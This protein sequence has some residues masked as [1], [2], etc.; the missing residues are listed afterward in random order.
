MRFGYASFIEERFPGLS[1][2]VMELEGVWADVDATGPV[3]RFTARALKRLQTET[4]GGFAEIQA[5]RRA[6]TKM[7]LK[8]TRYRCAS[9]ALLRRLRKSGSLPALHPLIDLCNAA[10]VAS[11]VPVA[12]FDMDRIQGDLC[13]RRAGGDER[14]LAFSGAAE[15]PDPGEVIFADA[16]G[17]AHARRWAHRQSLRSAVS[18]RTT[19]ALIVAEAQHAEATAQMQGLMDGLR[20]AI[21]EVSGIKA[22]GRLL[23]GPGDVF[24]SSIAGGDVGV[25]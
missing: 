16:G 13:V 11:A 10:S 23:D 5:W 1:T 17:H 3:G 12:V 20:D 7:G 25:G 2:C 4:E 19:R 21:A 18:D 24:V 22:G 15:T 6:Y 14:Y 9:E 8:P